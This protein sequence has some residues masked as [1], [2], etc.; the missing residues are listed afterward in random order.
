MAPSKKP[1][2]PK[3]KKQ[4][5]GADHVKSDAIDAPSM[6]SSKRAASPQVQRD[7]PF[8]IFVVPVPEDVLTFSGCTKTERDLVFPGFLHNCG[9]AGKI[10]HAMA[11]LEREHPRPTDP[12]DWIRY[13][14]SMQKYGPGDKQIFMKAVS[15][16]TAK[17][18]KLLKEKQDL[19]KAKVKRE[20]AAFAMQNSQPV[21]S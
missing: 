2:D 5:K 13:R 4:G 16:L 12:W 1:G 19:M 7:P 18:E 9:L 20:E 14:I 6:R 8:E 3:P 11:R 17:R 10:L 15:D 21:A